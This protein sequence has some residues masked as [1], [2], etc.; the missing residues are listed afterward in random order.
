MT[1]VMKKMN[2]LQSEA[3]VV[4]VFGLI[5]WLVIRMVRHTV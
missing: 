1:G 3:S 5:R 4:L 2:F